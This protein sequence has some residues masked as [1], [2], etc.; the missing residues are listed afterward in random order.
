MK[1]ISFLN[2]IVSGNSYSPSVC[3]HFV[4]PQLHVYAFSI[5]Q[6]EIVYNQWAKNRYKIKRLDTE[7]ITIDS[8]ETSINK[9]RVGLNKVVHDMLFSP[10]LIKKC[11][12]IF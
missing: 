12:R 5:V 3:L 7:F 10:E 11:F 9:C 1:I 4:A 8:N 2:V 6:R